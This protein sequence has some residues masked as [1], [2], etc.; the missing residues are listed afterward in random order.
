LEKAISEIRMVGPR[1]DLIQEGDP[2]DGVHVVLEG[3]ACRYKLLPSGERQ[4]MAYLVPGDMC[5]LHIAILG[6]MDHSIATLS[7][8]KIAII[9]HEAVES[10]MKSHDCINRALWWSSLVDEAILREWLVGIGRRSADKQLAHRLCEL[11]VRLQA[12]GL[13]TENSYQ[14]PVTQAELGDTLGISTVHVNRM[15]QQLRKAGLIA[16]QSHHPT[17][18]DV[19]GLKQF[20]EFTPNYLHLSASRRSQ[21][22]SPKTKGNDENRD[23]VGL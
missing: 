13:A 8:C 6:E 5:D 16:P 15:L 1:Q 12:V 23:T 14:F 7:A 17:I 11:L 21:D 3:F 10:L 4:I 20:A 18:T 19:D 2:P 9:P 22:A